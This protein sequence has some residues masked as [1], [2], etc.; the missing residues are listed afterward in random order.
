MAFRCMQCNGSMV[1]DIASQQMKCSHCGAVCAPQSFHMR[2]TALAV[3]AEAA[4]ESVCP[5]C[6]APLNAQEREGEACPYCGS[7]LVT[8]GEADGLS[9]FLCQNCGAELESTEDSMIGLCPYCGGQSM[10]KDPGRS[11]GEVERIIPFQ[12]TRERCGSLY[13]E[14]AKK[15]RYLPR[16]F[17]SAEHIQKFT[18]IYMPY[19]EYDAVFGEAA[20]TGTK[21][22][23]SNARYDVVNTYSIPAE[24]DGA[25]LRGS[26]FDGSKYLDDEIS[27]RS[28]PFDTTLEVAFHP[29]YLA[30]FY[31]DAS[32]VSPELYHTDAREQAEQD[33]VGV[34]KSRISEEHGIQLESSSKVETR[35][36]GHHS[37][38]FPLWFLT[39]R[40]GD[41]VAYAVINGA[42]GKV[43]SDLP[44]DLR[45]FWLGCGKFALVLFLLLELFFQPTPQLTS[46][47]SLLAALCMGGGI[48]LSTRTVY[49][50]QMHVHDKGWT[51][52]AAPPASSPK[53]EKTNPFTGKH[54]HLLITVCT[55]ALIAMLTLL[56]YGAEGSW[57]TL[58]GWCIPVVT[59][60]YTF[61]A[62]KRVFFWQKSI[63]QREGS[64]SI[65]LLMVTVIANSVIYYLSPASDLWYYLGDALCIVGL[66]L[67][68]LGMLHMYNVGTTRPL[69][70]LFDREEV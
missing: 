24:V 63:E 22:V 34:L 60:L 11:G 3:G 28:M 44:L 27:Q 58:V 59:V 31:A 4:D 37:V 33:V 61:Y 12:V 6:F 29:G 47:I 56:I 18:G 17:R 67:S 65:V 69:P 45:A 39:W 49:D 54:G 8:A 26:P 52:A 5:H 23:E 68:S 9:V 66:V 64:R 14:F 42:S 30:G 51:S 35:V 57:L 10:V 38:L 13:Q 15:I 7:P 41:R 46:L 20:L 53:R 19:Y 50:K 16:D 62:V 2:D 21:T 70:K 48:V 25:Y 32:T 1:F 36:T 43:V 40:K 55:W